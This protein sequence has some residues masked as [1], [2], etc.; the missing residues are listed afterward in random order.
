MKT[1]VQCFLKTISFFHNFITLC[2]N[3]KKKFKIIKLGMQRSQENFLFP[4]S[5]SKVLNDGGLEAV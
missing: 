2:L 1:I 4:G 5:S 3:I